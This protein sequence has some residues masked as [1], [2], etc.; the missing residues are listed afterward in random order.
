MKRISKVIYYA[1]VA[2]G[3]T[4]ISILMVCAI[5]LVIKDITS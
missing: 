1:S 3:L 4:Y 5:Y 2:A